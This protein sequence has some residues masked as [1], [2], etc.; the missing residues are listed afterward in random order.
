LEEKSPLYINETARSDFYAALRK[1]FWHSVVGWITHT[2]ST[3]LP[4]DEIRKSLPLSN[5]HYIGMREIPVDQIIGSVSRYRDF[6]RAFLPLQTTTQGRWMSIDRAHLS[7]II[8]P[9]IEVYKIGNTYYVKDGN[10]RVSVARQKGQKYIDADVIEI[11]VSV[12][13][14]PN[15]DINDLILRLEHAD[16]LERTRLNQVRPDADVRLSIPG[17]YERL[18]EHISVHR[19]FLGV[20]RKSDITWEEAVI[21]WVDQVYL[22]LVYVIR[23]YKILKGFPGRTETDLY[24]WIIEHLWY[25]REEY[26]SDVSLETA[27]THFADEFSR[28]P[29]RQLLSMVRRTLRFLSD[30]GQDADEFLP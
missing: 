2:R 19:Y 6:D 16:F 18:I 24:L 7:D 11:E 22:P 9:P 28:R 17:G 8:L 12:P 1:G 30:S 15:V 13:V 14:D 5:Q 27:A 20:Q 29:L 3:L 25:L 26:N 23:E 10:H 4:Y 21:G